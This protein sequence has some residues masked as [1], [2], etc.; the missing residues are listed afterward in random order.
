MRNVFLFKIKL[1]WRLKNL[2]SQPK[3]RNA[4]FFP[5]YL[6]I[7]QTGRKPLFLWPTGNCENMIYFGSLVVASMWVVNY[8]ADFLLLKGLLGIAVLFYLICHCWYW[9]SSGWIEVVASWRHEAFPQD[10]NILPRFISLHESW[11]HNCTEDRFL[12]LSLNS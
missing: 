6:L 2:V 11:Y 5:S 3:K 7:V 10:F 12:L 1:N 9:F 8:S 4:D